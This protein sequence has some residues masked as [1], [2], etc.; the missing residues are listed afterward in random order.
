MLSRN[1]TLQKVGDFNWLKKH[2]NFQKI[3]FSIDELVILNVTRNDRDIN[4]FAEAVKEVISNVFIPVSVGGGIRSLSD[5]DLLL[6]SGADK[7][8]LNTPLYSDKKLVNQ[9]VKK[10]GSQ[11]VVGSVDYKIEDKNNVVFIENG[12]KKVEMDFT[13]YLNY[14]NSLNIGEVYLNS[15]DRD[16]TGQG[17]DLLNLKNILN[18]IKCPLIIAGGAGNMYHLEE[19]LTSTHI[20]AV[21]TANLF[22]FLGDSLPKSREHII[23]KKIKIANWK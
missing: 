21:A 23:E 11:F 20:D 5:A 4:M 1:F 16:G 2:Y 7:I 14:I 12:S 8:I 15:I 22:N 9:L 19:G 13:K 3:A 6:K 18:K 10:Y 17:L